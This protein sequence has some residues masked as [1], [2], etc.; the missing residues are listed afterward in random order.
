MKNFKL[1]AIALVAMLGF[2]AC[3]KD[4]NH[5]FIEHDFTQDI[6]GTWTFVEDDLA[7]AMV[8]K[9]DGSFT[10]TGVMKGG[11]LYEEKGTIKVVNNKVTLAF[12]GDKDT[13]EG[14]LEF[15]AGKSLSL[16][17]FDDNDV[18]LTYDYC[19][20]DLS[21]EILGMWVCNDASTDAQDMM[22]Q[23][24]DKNG[25][26]TLTGYL[27]L[28][29]D[30]EQAKNEA[31]DYKV[32]GDLL[33]ITIPAEKIG[34]EE[35]IY[36]VDKLTYAPDGTAYGDILTLKTYIEIDGKFVES[37]W[38]YLR[39]KQYLNLDNKVYDY[40]SAYVSN[41]KGKD[42]DFTIGENVFN[43]STIKA[44]NFDMMFRSVLSCFEFS[45]NSFTYKFRS[46]DMDIEF[47]TPITVDGNKVT[48]DMSKMNPACRTVV[49][50]MFQDKDD[51]QL[52]MYMH[53][54]AFINYFAN[55][56]VATLIAMGEINQTDEAAIAKVFA[57]ME[58]RVESINVSFVLK[59]RK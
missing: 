24:F 18:R 42:E 11:Y 25:K 58:A 36:V 17:M 38:S 27:P 10:T 16:V 44:G 9:A 4:C 37:G 40:I 46:N 50:H 57:D 3:E 31:T 59:A 8:I 49:M 52:H 55:V 14:R 29:D 6:V 35:P 15:V 47:A 7:E 23:T 53:T 30:S 1:M 32:V 56:E 45:A 28:E 21:D 33:F 12:D 2:S 13:F 34:K 51:S 41:A 22:I 48:L 54:D 20:N 43:M 26:C 19:E 39:V 5:D